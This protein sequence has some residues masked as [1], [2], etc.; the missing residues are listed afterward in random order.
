MIE[1]SITPYVVAATRDTPVVMIVGPRQAGK[2]TLALALADHGV[3]AG[4]ESLDI[5]VNLAAARSDPDGYLADLDYPVIIDEV[6]KAPHLLSAIKA[7]VDRDRKPGRFILT[8]SANIFLQPK[9]FE[10]LAGRMETFTLWPLSEGEI[11]GSTDNF[12]SSAFNPEAN[13]KGKREA[14]G[15]L[16]DALLRG[17]FP[18]LLDRTPNRR[19]AWFD[20]YTSALIERDLRAIADIEHVDAVTNM[21]FLLAERV[22]MPLN[23]TQLG[24]NL[25]ISEATVRRYLGLLERVYFIQRIS[26]YSRQVKTRI[27]K[28]SRFLLSDSG[29]LAHLAQIDTGRLKRNRQL[30]G[31]LLENFVGNELVKQSLWSEPRATVHY[32][33]ISRGPEADFLLATRDGSVVA[34]EVRA[35]ATVHE[36]D[37]AHLKALSKRFGDRFIRGVVLYT[38]ESTVGFGDKI[39]AVPISALWR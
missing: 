8:G 31:T 34:V 25:G 12:V 15:D 24:S 23:A 2:S 30:L 32:L 1:R 10:S 3:E 18:E 38:G 22:Q 28:A 13:L 5:A 29:L 27:T 39:T 4:F 26:A 7:H 21:L 16:T 37:T 35:A 11:R 17:G 20:E 6:Q 33:R 14:R 36:Q 9:V 19:A